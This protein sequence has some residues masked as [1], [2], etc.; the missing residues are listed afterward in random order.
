MGASR[1]AAPELSRV[2]TSVV[3]TNVA[4]WPDHCLPRE[5]NQDGWFAFG[6]LLMTSW[7]LVGCWTERSPGRAP[8]R[9]LSTQTAM[10]RTFSKLLA[11]RRARRSD[12]SRCR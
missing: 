9:I 10:Y 12:T 1:T 6:D 11:P 3:R 5:S 4:Y 7:N 8:F 2:N